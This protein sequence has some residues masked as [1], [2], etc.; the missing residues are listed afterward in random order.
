MTNPPRVLR[1][2]AEWEGRR[3]CE[4]SARTLFSTDDFCENGVCRPS[5]TGLGYVAPGLGWLGEERGHRNMIRASKIKLAIL[6]VAIVVGA[7]AYAEVDLEWRPEG[8]D[9]RVGQKVRVGFYAVADNGGGNEKFSQ[10]QAIV[11]WDAHYL[12]LLRVHNNGPY[13]WLFSGFPDD[14]ALDGL[15]NT[16]DD[17]NAYYQAWRGFGPPPEATPNG[18]LVTTMEFEA[19]A[20]T[21]RTEITLVPDSGEFSRTVVFDDEIPG[22]DIAGDLGSVSV[23]ISSGQCRGDLDGDG[24]VDLADLSILLSCYGR[25]ESCGDTDG[26]GDTDLADMSLLLAN[27]GCRSGS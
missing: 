6:P 7:A 3:S 26:D 25:N 4:K 9:F 5:Q 12:K 27:W 21:Q 22:Y 15:N 20:A 19:L 1:S 16:F 17:G 24:D 13:R 14:S 10:I 18:L 2:A 11:V 8:S 23:R